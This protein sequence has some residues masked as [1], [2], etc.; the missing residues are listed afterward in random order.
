MSKVGTPQESRPSYVGTSRTIN[1]DEAP[2]KY[3]PRIGFIV[4]FDYALHIPGHYD[5]V[6]IVYGIYRNGLVVDPPRSVEWKEIK[7]KAFERD[8]YGYAV[9]NNKTLIKD[10]I[11]YSGTCL[12]IE[13]QVSVNKKKTDKENPMNYQT[14][15]SEQ[16]TL[17]YELYRFWGEEEKDDGDVVWQEEDTSDQFIPYAWTMAELF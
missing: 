12:I 16:P 8:G 5:N 14:H 9:F 1:A 4:E 15:T 3:H 13:I 2:P 6:R 10:I 11:A 17:G 7:T